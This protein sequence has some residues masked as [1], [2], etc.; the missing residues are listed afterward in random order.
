MNIYAKVKKNAAICSDPNES[1]VI[2]VLF[3]LLLAGLLT[4]VMFT[5]GLGDW[6]FRR[7]ELQLAADTAASDAAASFCSTRSCW[8]YSLI[9]ALESLDRMGVRG[10]TNSARFRTELQAAIADLKSQ[11]ANGVKDISGANG[12]KRPPLGI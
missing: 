5:V 9:N 7:T 2:I 11:L 3:A 8:N 4:I 10:V 1:G 12:Q 6:T